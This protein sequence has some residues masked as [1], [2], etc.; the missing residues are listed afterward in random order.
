MDLDAT[1]EQS[2]SIATFGSY[3]GSTKVCPIVDVG[4]CP[5]GYPPMSPSLYVYPLFVSH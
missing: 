2:L 5:K 1:G 4:M 3:K